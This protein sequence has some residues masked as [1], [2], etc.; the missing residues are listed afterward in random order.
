MNHHLTKDKKFLSDKYQIINRE[1]G[2]DVSL[3]KVVLSLHD[4]FARYSLVLYN[5]PDEEFIK[6]F[7][8]RIEAIEKE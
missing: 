1:T 5:G 3:D 7:S 4:P 6:D 8:D 2:E